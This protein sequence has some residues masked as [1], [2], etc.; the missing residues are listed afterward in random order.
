MGELIVSAGGRL[1]S[2]LRALGKIIIAFIAAYCRYF[3]TAHGLFFGYTM[4]QTSP[5]VVKP[6]TSLSDDPLI[7]PPD[8][9]QTLIGSG[10]S[11]WVEMR[12]QKWRVISRFRAS[13]YD[14][15][16]DGR[17]HVAD[18]QAVFFMS[19]GQRLRV[20]GRDGIVA[21]SR[22]PQPGEN[23]R[24]LGSANQAPTRGELHDVRIDLFDSQQALDQ[25]SPENP[26]QILRLTMDNAALTM[27]QPVFLPVTLK[28]IRALF[29]RI[30][31]RW[32]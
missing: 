9:P 8:D 29:R 26:T 5:V 22:L 14:P 31:C 7:A 24:N 2:P 15:R 1:I 32:L 11:A 27:R 12:D 18:P 19:N 17:V 4:L 25:D 30:A 20:S 3:G 13:R 23:P 21:M 10:E 16:K 6:P 28:L